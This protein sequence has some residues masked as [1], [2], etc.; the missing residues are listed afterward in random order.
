MR[1]I[2]L[3][4]APYKI[5]LNFVNPSHQIGLDSYQPINFPARQNGSFCRL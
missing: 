3:A 5:H 2:T 4:L 1:Q